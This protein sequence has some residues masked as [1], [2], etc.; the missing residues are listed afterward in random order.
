MDM[1]STEHKVVDELRP[2]SPQDDTTYARKM[3][4]DPPVSC[5]SRRS[6]LQYSIHPDGLAGSI[7]TR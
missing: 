5:G 2:T 7:F 1:L 3:S 6:G 4:T